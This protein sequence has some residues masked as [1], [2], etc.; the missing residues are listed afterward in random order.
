MAKKLGPGRC[1]IV[2]PDAI[3]S[4]GAAALG[5]RE[6]G[7]EEGESAYVGK[8]SALIGQN[9]KRSALIGRDEKRRALTGRESHAH[10]LLGRRA[11]PNA[12][13]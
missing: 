13:L 12:A 2:T 5:P 8:R 9:E 1:V 11:T 4:C 7:V 3:L 10:S 6:W